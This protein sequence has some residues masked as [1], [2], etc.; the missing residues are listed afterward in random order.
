MKRIASEYSL[1]N[2]LFEK[3]NVM[4][5]RAQKESNHRLVIL[6]I[7]KQDRQLISFPEMKHE[8]E[9]L[10][11]FKSPRII[12]AHSLEVFE[13]VPVLILEDFDEG[14]SLAHKIGLQKLSIIEFL[15]IALELVEAL[16]EIHQNFVLHS[17]LNPENILINYKT[18]K[19]QICDFSG[20]QVVNQTAILNSI[21]NKNENREPTPYYSPEQQGTIHHPLDFRTDI[22]SLGVILYELLMGRL[23]PL[24][25]KAYSPEIPDLFVPIFQKSLAF[26]PEKRYNSALEFKKDIE[27]CLLKVSNPDKSS[28]SKDLMMQLEQ[29]NQDL[30]KIIEDLQSRI[31]QQEKLSS[32]GFLTAGVAH[33]LKNPLNFIINFAQMASEIGHDIEVK[34][35][36]FPLEAELKNELSVDISAMQEMLQKINNNGDRANKIIKGMLAY[37]REDSSHISEP[38]NIIELI[39]QSIGLV[40]SSFRKTNMNFTLS[41]VREYEKALPNISTVPSDLQRVFLNIIDNACYAMAEKKKQN[42]EGYKP[43][44]RITIKSLD[45][46]IEITFE[47][48]GTGMSA[49]AMEKAFQPFYTSKP[50]GLGTGLGLSIAQDIITREHKGEIKVFSEPN[51]YT[52]FVIMLPKL[53]PGVVNKTTEEE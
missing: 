7:S 10:K 12:Q 35:S 1:K 47:D 17:D 23:P 9:I 51:L 50:P 32:L 27:D 14:E 31:I 33:E 44:L 8:L 52:K 22:Y 4:A 28:S 43:I 36:N 21:N 24:D 30:L 37:S 13:D 29:R 26:M 53:I 6:K 42:I 40:Y 38:T 41:F 20:S 18:G 34:C 49:T 48:N 5:Y 46:F 25:L 3:K 19:I 11:L 39:E 15:T 45:D 2:L 16:C